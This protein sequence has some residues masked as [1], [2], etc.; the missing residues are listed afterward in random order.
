MYV[1]AMLAIID[2]KPICIVQKNQNLALLI[3]VGEVSHKDAKLRG[4]YLLAIVVELHKFNNANT[5]LAHSFPE[6]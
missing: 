3:I 4:M 5:C 2:K 6:K 1:Y